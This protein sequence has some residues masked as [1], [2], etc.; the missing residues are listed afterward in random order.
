MPKDFSAP[1][2]VNPNS[3]HWGET[4]RTIF[5]DW[6]DAIQVRLISGPRVDQIESA[7]GAMQHATWGATAQ[8]AW[9]RGEEEFDLEAL[10]RGGSLPL[11]AEIAHFTFEISGVS[12]IITH[13]I[14]RTRVGVTYSQRGTGDQDCRHDDVLVPRSLCRS[15]QEALLERYIQG[16]LEAKLLYAEMIDSKEHSLVMARY[17]LPQNLAQFIYA[18]Y[19]YL[20][21]VGL[22]AKR[23]CT[24]ETLEFNVV[25]QRMKEAM[26]AGGYGHFASL[27]RA[28]CDSPQ[29]CH[30]MRPR[31]MA[32]TVYPP[33]AKHDRFPWNPE[34]YV[35]ERTR[36]ELLDGPEFPERWYVGKLLWAYH[37]AGR[38]TS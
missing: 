19:S 5:K 30:Y 4:P 8:D 22:A 10:L 14:V 7:M 9:R 33:D 13:Q 29:G 18:D 24:Y 34:N 23:L 3:V 20:A 2:F 11:G 26:E 6:I 25:L 32:G 28:A 1:I 16:A 36:D 12:R 21:L 17:V 15:G 38:E 31:R 27:L 37:A 35:Y